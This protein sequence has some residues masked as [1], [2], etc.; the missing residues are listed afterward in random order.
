L[1][2]ENGAGKSTA[3]K[4]CSGH[5][6]PSGG[7]VLVD[8]RPLTPATPEEAFR[9]G[10]GLVHQHFM[11]VEAF[12]ALENLMLGAEPVGRA[13]QLLELAAR[14][15]AADAAALAGFSVDL[16]ARAGSLAVGERQRLEILRVLYRGAQA[17]LLDEPTAVL[18]PLEVAELY[19]VLRRLAREGSTVVVVSHRLDEVARFAD[20]V[21][22]MRAGRL[23]H[24][25]RIA[26]GP[27]AVDAARDQVEVA[28]AEDHS[29]AADPTMLTRLTL[30][31]MGGRP[32]AA[33]RQ[34]DRAAEPP[35]KLRVEGVDLAT[36]DGTLAL[37]G[38][39]LSVG[40][41]E[42]VGIAGVE[43]NGQRELCRVL[44]GLEVPT[45]GRLRVGAASLPC[46][47]G[48]P[49][50]VRAARAAGLV[51]VQEDRH[52]DELLLEA[53]VGDNLV[54]GDLA[55]VDEREAVA[56]RLDRFP[57]SPAD[58]R[59][60]AAELSGGN[61]QKLVVAR[62]LDRT[63]EV[64]VL[65]QPTRGVDVGTARVIHQAIVDA[66]TG[67]TAVL[68]ISADLEELRLLCHRLLVLRRGRVVAELPPDV[69][70]EEIGRAMLGTSSGEEP[71]A[72][73]EGSA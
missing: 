32:P 21:S 37:S 55:T 51:V 5:L 19:A 17:L 47:R 62:A 53:T 28:S 26:R 44:G 70:D 66:A 33:L 8:G 35:P 15:R 13:G 6:V 60:R 52:R 64:L 25:E 36:A 49:D 69:G 10:I 1:I 54:L 20:E 38:I 30:A 56:R 63:P 12:S 72:G 22:V 59:R 57:V 67:G 3:L 45:R 42:I 29:Q 48:G 24:H 65:A 50:A 46:R 58:P 71:H 4:L 73:A 43:G 40:A 11:L 7:E 61:Q 2:G 27:S 9:R 16:D 31:I 23:V 18:T 68:V 14:R 34:S 41:G 39:E